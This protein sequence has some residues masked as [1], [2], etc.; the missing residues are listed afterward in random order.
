MG[1]EF[2]QACKIAARRFFLSF[3]TL[4]DLCG[5]EIASGLNADC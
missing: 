1:T 5:K 2:K 4:C 3:A